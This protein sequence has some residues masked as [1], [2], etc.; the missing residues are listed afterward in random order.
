MLHEFITAH[1]EAIIARARQKLIADPSWPAV[2]PEDIESGVPIFLTQLAVALQSPA[3][4]TADS[5]VAI[6]AAATRHGEA[7]LTRGFSVSQVVH[8][9]GEVC[10]AIT[11]MAIDEQAPI[12]T[13]EFRMLNGCLDTAIAEAVTEHARLSAAS[14]AAGESERSGRLAHETRDLLNTALLAYH[15]LKR[16][17]VAVN[18]STGAVLGRSLIGLRDLVESNLSEIRL[19]ARQQRREPVS[20][21]ALLGDIAVAGR[22]QAELRVMAF[23]LAPGDAAWTVAADP[24]LLASAVTNLL[25]NA[26][27]FTRPGGRVE[28][29]ATRSE[30]GRLQIEVEDRC[31][32]IPDHDSDPFKPFGTRRG[33]DRTGLGLGLSIA[34]KAARAH[35]GD[36]Q[37]RNMP[38]MGCV[39][40]IDL[41]FATEPAAVAP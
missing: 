18:G 14:W 24:Q 11:E 7:L 15:S 35:H 9:Y 22:L 38:G 17:T 37:I 8:G 27:K 36:I 29:R 6:G 4:A 13:D 33:R 10:Q 39:F 2:S 30:A 16:G 12:T 26:F 41:P 25:N 28:L 3:A 1:R 19:T 40:T 20:V 34:R 21:S 23:T 5:A 31:G 32:G